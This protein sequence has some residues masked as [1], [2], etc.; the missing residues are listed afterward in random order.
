MRLYL[1]RHGQS[2]NNAT[3]EVDR[4]ADP[5][6]SDLG[7]QQ[8]EAVATYLQSGMKEVQGSVTYHH[9]GITKLYCSP[10]LRTLQTCQP[11]SQALGLKPEVWIEIHEHGGLYLD[12]RDERGVVGFSGLTRADILKQFADYTLPETF[13]ETGWWNPAS[14]EEA[15]TGAQARAIKV[16]AALREQADSSEHI[17]LVTH[18][19]FMDCLLK[20][21]FY[22]LPTERHYFSHNNTGIT[23]LDFLDKKHVTIR[24]MNQIDHLK[25][26]QIS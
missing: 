7:K 17:A 6:L 18:G 1:I 23:R 20:A 3:N 19:T 8:A 22:Q 10:M 24:Y 12:Y 4:V 16:A 9:F 25:P 5:P 2:T 21:F 15:I 14:G 11:I 26:E 13:G